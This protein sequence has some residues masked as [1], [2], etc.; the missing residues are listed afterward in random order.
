MEISDVHASAGAPAR[1]A[2]LVLG[3]HRSGTSALTRVIGLSGAALPRNKMEPAK[4][5]A[6][7]FWEPQP[8][9]DAH[10]RFLREAGTGWEAIAG[11]P[12]T[13]FASDAA[14]DC[15]RI[16]AALVAQEFG[17][18]PLFILKDPRVSR[19]MKLW[20]PLLSELGIAPRIIIMVRNPLEIA[21]S[22]RT[23]DGWSEHRALMVWLRYMLAAERD[24]RDLVRCF[25]GYDQLMNDWRATVG[26]LC[27]RLGLALPAPG[28]AVEREIDGFIRPDLRHH[29]H[30]ADA[31]L[32]RDDIADCV[33][34][35]WRCFSDAAETGAVDQTALDRITAALNA[36]E[37]TLAHMMRR[38][39][40]PASAA[41]AG[42]ALTAL[43]VAE[44]EHAQDDADHARRL[45]SQMRATWS[46]RL[47]KPFRALGRTVQGLV[48]R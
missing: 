45:V 20:R 27:E 31:L 10:D 34:Q 12:P 14:A 17:D 3:M 37:A 41:D 9:V 40:G 4:D 46:W 43:M 6:L 33:K 19:L 7:G 42:D 23:R 39:A 44:L 8:I 1:Q 35:A 26:S 24:T 48:G 25:V 30:R 2:L 18:A 16:L 22:L 32:Q 5:N 38:R 29:R 36:A 15:R 21:A 47:T 13:I 28:P 11:Y